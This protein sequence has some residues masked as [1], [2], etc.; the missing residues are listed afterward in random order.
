M[1]FFHRS[2]PC[3]V[4]ELSDVGVIKITAGTFHSLAQTIYSQV[5]D[6]DLL[7]LGNHDIAS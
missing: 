4:K 1:L 5:I 7:N 6:T 3:C 2:L